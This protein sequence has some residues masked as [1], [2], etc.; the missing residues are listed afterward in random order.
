MGRG[1]QMTP[2]T[3]RGGLCIKLHVVGGLARPR[4]GAFDRLQ[5]F[6]LSPDVQHVPV[7]VVL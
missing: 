4:P 2:H 5:G 1:T 3:R 7:S 6:G